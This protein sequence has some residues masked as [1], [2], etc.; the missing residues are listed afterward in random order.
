[1]NDLRW[2]QLPLLFV[3]S[4][5]LLPII[6]TTTFSTPEAYG[7]RDPHYPLDVPDQTRTAPRGSQYGNKEACMHRYN[8]SALLDAA[9]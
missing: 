9:R 7:V 4:L 5:L 3:L 8:V 1:M 6:I 2:F